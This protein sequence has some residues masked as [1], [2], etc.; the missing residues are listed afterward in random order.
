M[1]LLGFGT[2]LK[3]SLSKGGLT[4]HHVTPPVRQ[5]NQAQSPPTRSASNPT[6]PNGDL[7]GTALDAIDT[8]DGATSHPKPFEQAGESIVSKLNALIGLGFLLLAHPVYAT[9]VQEVGLTELLQRADLVFEGQ[10]IE[11]QPQKSPHYPYLFTDVTVQTTQVFKG[12]PHARVIL[13]IPGG[14]TAQEKVLVH[15]MPSFHTDQQILIFAEKLPWKQEQEYFLPLGL[16]LGFFTLE[17]DFFQRQDEGLD[18]FSVH[19]W[20]TGGEGLNRFQAST[21]RRELIAL[22]ASAQ[23]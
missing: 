14:S 6:D 1:C 2:H 21:F 15:G 3:D 20:C 23:E 8:R 18:S 9:T 10:V 11:V 5:V 12:G 16:G 4:K 17:N 22:Q 13:R 7:K 19:P